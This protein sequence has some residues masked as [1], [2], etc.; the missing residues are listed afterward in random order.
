LLFTSFLINQHTG[1]AP[2]TTK[3]LYTGCD[4][5]IMILLRRESLL[6]RKPQEYGKREAINWKTLLLLKI[7]SED[8][9][10]GKEIK[11]RIFIIYK[12]ITQCGQH[13]ISSASG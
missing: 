9:S 6:R 11:Y 2:E 4:G 8:F 1:L 3:D 5:R 13:P 12:H 7:I 10:H